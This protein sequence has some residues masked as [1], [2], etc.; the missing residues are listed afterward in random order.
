MN[1]TLV[2]PTFAD[3]LARPD[4]DHNGVSPE[5][6]AAHP[7]Y[8][9]DNSTNLRCWN[10]AKCVDCWG[11]INCLYCSDSD[12]LTDCS[13]LYSDSDRIERHKKPFTVPVVPNLHQRVLAAAQQ[14]GV[15]DVSF[16]YNIP[17]RLT[18]ARWVVHLA[19]EA[20]KKLMKRVGDSEAAIYICHASCPALPMSNRQFCHPPALHLPGGYDQVLS[21]IRRC[22]AFEA[23][24]RDPLY[25]TSLLPPRDWR[26]TD[27]SH[28]LLAS[29]AGRNILLQA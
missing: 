29:L 5:F 24:F 22:A 7:D 10:C 9:L 25:A 4:L 3:F 12:G 15:L 26:P 27:L 8:A 18:W 16:G 21:D 20:G 17:T 2:Y 6:A 11:C 19:G 13:Y 1:R 14:P 23:G 28:K